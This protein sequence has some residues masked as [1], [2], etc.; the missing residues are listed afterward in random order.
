MASAYTSHADVLDAHETLH[1]TFRTGKTKNLAWRKWQ[2]KQCWWLLHENA[3][4]IVDSITKDLGR[5]AFESKWTEILT[6]KTKILRTI[7][8]LEQWT[9]PAF[10]GGNGVI[11]GRLPHLTTR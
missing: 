8:C 1:S 4:A 11:F 5:D 7:E 9:A 3:E 10:P 2:L 6:L